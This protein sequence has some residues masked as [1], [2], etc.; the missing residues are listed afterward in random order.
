MEEQRLLPAVTRRGFLKA[1]GAGS[2]VVFADTRNFFEGNVFAALEESNGILTTRLIRP[3]DQLRLRFDFINLVHDVAN[4]RLIAG[5]SGT[6]LMRLTMAR[7]HLTEQPVNVGNVPGGAGAAPIPHRVSSE[8]RLVFEVTPPLDLSVPVLLD[9]ARHVLVTPTGAGN[10][11]LLQSMIEVPA[12]LRLAPGGDIDMVADIAP[13]V[14]VWPGPF[15]LSNRISQLHR[16]ILDAPGDIELTPVHNAANV[17]G[18]ARR[19]PNAG[20]RSEFVSLATAEGPATAE[21]MWLTPHGAWA[22]LVGEWSTISWYQ[23]VRAGRDQFA[24]VVNRGI[25]M[26]FGHPAVWTTTSTRLWLVDADGDIVSTMVTDEQFAVVGASTVEFPGLHS[27]SGGRSMPFRSVTIEQK[28]S[29]AVEKGSITWDGGSIST[30]DAWIV[31]HAPGP[32]WGG[33][34]VRVSYSAIDGLDHDPATFSQG[35]VFVRTESLGTVASSLEDFYASDAAATLNRATMRN[36]VAWA[37]EEDA[38]SGITTLLTS[39]IVFGVEHITGVSDA[40]LAAAGQ[41]RVAPIVLQGVV[42]KLD[43]STQPTPEQLDIA[44]VFNPAFLSDGNNAVLNPTRAFLDLVT[45]T[46]F[47]LGTEARSV[48]TPELVA[49]QFNQSLGIGPALDS[50]GGGGAGG[51]TWRPEDA[52]GVDATILRGVNFADLVLPILF[53]I[54]RPGIDIPEFTIDA[55]PD[56]L[57]QSYRWCPDSISSVPIAG[58]I[59]TSSTTLCVEV[60]AVVGLEAGVEASVTIVFEVDDF[61]LVV[62]PLISLVELD[63]NSMKATQTSSGN[64]DLTFDIAAWRLGGALSW[65]EPLISLLSPN[66]G[67]FDVVI[68]DGAIAIDLELGL[69]NINLGVLEIKNFTIGLSGSFPFTGT[70]EPT[71]GIGVGSRDKPVSLQ[72]MQFAGGFWCEVV[73]SPQ[74]LELLHVHAEVSAMLVEIDIVIAQAYCSVT[75]GADFTLK[76][77]NVTFS[78]F[79]KLTA[80]FNVL[81]LVGATLEIV[82]RVTYKEVAEEITISGTI[83]WSVT[84][85]ATFSGKVPIGELTFS[86]GSGSG[87]GFA[88]L[89]GRALPLQASADSPAGGS[90]GD[91][92]TFTTWTTY[93]DKFAA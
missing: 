17:D 61:T 30:N 32:V 25:L 78:G 80:S 67:D 73:F 71:I 35:A 69:P 93:V 5:P 14:A 3:D 63:I 28:D 39:E 38:G 64:T 66:G 45:P 87:A 92:H 33:S 50:S 29:L 21:R 36:D 83:Y 79:L 41:L 72:I 11:T 51:D 12:D 47:P 27:P 8:S 34:P 10:P 42:S 60:T 57:I 44:V 26:P 56:R 4:D 24:Q 40:D 20:D 1:I 55:L 59:A 76:N 74:G 16:I 43:G 13:I 7:Q 9:L 46:K 6:P 75:V 68:V 89:S 58:F 70:A 48:M 15:G 37:D 85:L 54:A 91:A 53:D 82:G 49:E 2:V 22:D 18:F 19:L 90:F 88:S 77:G 86:T 65:L 52:F 84:A 81:G 31:N 23:N 62:P